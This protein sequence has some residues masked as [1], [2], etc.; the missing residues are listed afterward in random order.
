M[1]QLGTLYIG[2][3]S[4]VDDLFPEW[5]ITDEQ[6]TDQALDTILEPA[7]PDHIN[8]SVLK[9]VREIFGIDMTDDSTFSDSKSSKTSHTQTTKDKK[10]QSRPNTAS[11]E[12]EEHDSDDKARR[13]PTIFL[14]DPHSGDDQYSDFKIQRPFLSDPVT[15]QR[16]VSVSDRAKSAS[17]S[18]SD[19]LSKV[20]VSFSIYIVS[21]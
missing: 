17:S 12:V 13:H 3:I 10:K 5:D 4:N 11:P 16:K 19:A 1:S 8:V 18:T 2:K 7:Y 20:H 6:W 9:S 14:D 21:F 15:R